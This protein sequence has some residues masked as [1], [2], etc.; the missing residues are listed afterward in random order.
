MHANGMLGSAQLGHIKPNDCA[1][2]KRL[3]IV[4]KARVP[5]L[6]FVW[7]NCVCQLPLL[8]LLLFLWVNNWQKFMQCCQI[9]H[10]FKCIEYLCKLCKEY[11]ISPTFSFCTFSRENLETFDISHVFLP[12][13]VAKLSTLKN[14]VVFTARCYASAVLAMALCMS[15]CPSQVGVLLKRLNVGSCKQHHTIAQGR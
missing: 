6:N 1:A 5:I 8:L 12:V 9:Q 3:M 14:S 10:N 11:L 15:V 2:V 13:T 7:T 4:I